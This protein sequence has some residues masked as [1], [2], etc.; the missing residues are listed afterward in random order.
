MR[1]VNGADLRN[2]FGGMRSGKQGW[3]QWL[4]TLLFA[5]LLGWTVPSNAREGDST[6]LRPA[7]MFVQSGVT[8][9]NTSSYTVGVSWNWDWSRD[10]SFGTATGYTEV[11][12][13]RWA[14]ENQ[15]DGAG[16]NRRDWVTQVGI[17]PVIRI[18]PHSQ[19]ADWFVEGG[20][21]VNLI[22]PFYRDN[23]RR[24]GT[25]FNFGDH[26]G[27]GREF[28][29]YNHQEVSLRLQ[30]FSNAGIK[31]PNPGENFLQIRYSSRY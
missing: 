16:G 28:G 13:G 9:G 7:V 21:G 4:S 6:G 14:T 27:I 22:R 8:T 12:V 3:Q 23:D 31:E 29:R 15:R 5:A 30:H 26:L 17:T 24:F 2:N 1:G 20:V 18:H 10:F 25:E 19:F 11:A